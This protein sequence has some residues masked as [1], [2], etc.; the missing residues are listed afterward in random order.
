[1]WYVL[2]IENRQNKYKA[3]GHPCHDCIA[4]QWSSD[5]NAKMME[6][7]KSKDFVDIPYNYNNSTK[8][9][10]KC[11]YNGTC[12]KACIVYK[13]TW[14]SFQ[15]YILEWPKITTR[16]EWDPIS[17]RS[18]DKPRKAQNL[19]FMLNTWPSTSTIL[20]SKLPL[21]RQEEWLTCKYCGKGNIISCMKSFG[22][23]SCKLCIK[24]K[25][26]ILKLQKQDPT[27]I[28]TSNS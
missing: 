26:S 8:V 21:L 23:C 18:R 10:G 16:T 11:T 20:K 28:I 25:M 7:I 3:G 22:Q 6:N 19:I 5:L 15:N 9:N 13:A 12:R 24:E 1:M 4:K 27:H 17:V 2:F 14:K